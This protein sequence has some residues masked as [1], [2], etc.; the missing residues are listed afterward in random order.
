MS[1]EALLSIEEQEKDST[2]G[3][4]RGSISRVYHALCKRRFY[5]S[6]LSVI[7]HA[8]ILTFFITI[9]YVAYDEGLER[10]APRTYESFVP[11]SMYS[12]GTRRVGDLLT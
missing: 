9:V 1:R 10:Q 4:K 7:H 6:G 12:S 11:Q 5:T 8:F 3:D 2:Y